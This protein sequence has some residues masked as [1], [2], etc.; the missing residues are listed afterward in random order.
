MSVWHTASGGHIRGVFPD[1]ES[2]SLTAP[3]A[4][5]I[6]NPDAVACFLRLTH[7]RYYQHLKEFFGTTIIAM[8][9]DEPQ[10]MGRNPLR[11][12]NPMPF[13]PGLIEWLAER[14]GE[15]PR[16]WL[17][18]L[19]VDYGPGTG[20]FRRRFKAAIQERLEEV[21]F[22][23][24]SRWCAEHGI[25]L[26]GAS[27]RE[28]GAVPAALVPASGAGHGVA[29]RGTRPADRDRGPS[30]RGRQGG[31]QRRPHPGRPPH[32]DRGVRRL[33]LA[34]DPGRD[35]VAVRLALGARQQPDR[36]AR[37]VLLDPRPPRLGERAR[38]V[39]AQHLAP[40]RRHGQPLRATAELAAV[41]RRP[42]VRRGDPRRRQRHPLAGGEA[43][44]PAADRLPLPGPARGGEGGS[45]GRDPGG[46]DAVLPGRGRGRRSGAR[47]GCTP[48][49]AGIR[50]RRRPHSRIHR[51]DG[52]ARRA[53]PV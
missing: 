46:R 6:L 24:Q 5:D 45:R 32:P 44:L 33:R 36:P 17:P 34:P 35:E 15:D 48:R 50:R 39:P 43:A 29:L 7:D 38:S 18:A 10:V 16:P 9:T 30:Q 47:R 8:F 11:P 19:W 51:R 37:R 1:E 3:P 40:L 25:A 21:F 52:T 20:A 42:D 23:A 4:G 14:W 26:T 2:G 41:R 13:T 12:A 49:A 53:S 31:D 28:R 22:A 27:G